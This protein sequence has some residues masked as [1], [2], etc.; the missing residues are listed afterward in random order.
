[1]TD[2][3]TRDHEIVK[4]PSRVAPELSPILRTMADGIETSLRMFTRASYTTPGPSGPETQPCTEVQYL[5]L[6]G[7]LAE[8]LAA[9]R[10]TLNLN[11]R[12]LAMEDG[13]A[14]QLSTEPLEK[15]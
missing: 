2:T 15:E 9:Y 8:Q 11:D 10:A 12:L 14:V 1:M 13:R 6:S 7:M 5:R 3:H 4:R